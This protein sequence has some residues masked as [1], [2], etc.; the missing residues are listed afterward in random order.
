VKGPTR[1]M[2]KRT[3]LVAWLAAAVIG[4]DAAPAWADMAIGAGVAMYGNPVIWWLLPGVVLVEAIVARRVL[5]GSAAESVLMSFVVN[6]ASTLVGLVAVSVLFGN[7]NGRS[8]TGDGI[9]LVAAPLLF[10]VSVL[11][12]A[13][14]ASRMVPAARRSRVLRWAIEANLITYAMM[15]IAVVV[16]EWAAASTTIITFLAKRGLI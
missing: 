5:G 9:M 13:P 4:C 10:A 14:I 8:T 12:E 11:V 16:S 1:L 7:V 15:A 2:T 3:M 6:F